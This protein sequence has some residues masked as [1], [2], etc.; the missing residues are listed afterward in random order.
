MTRQFENTI[1]VAKMM[2]IMMVMMVLMTMA[3]MS[4]MVVGEVILCGTYDPKPVGYN[5][6]TTRYYTYR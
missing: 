2:M 4:R 1:V 3:M 5:F 6:S